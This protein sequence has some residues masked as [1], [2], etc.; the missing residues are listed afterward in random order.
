MIILLEFTAHDEELKDFLEQLNECKQKTLA[1]MPILER[2]KM[3]AVV[4]GW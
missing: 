3:K 4:F 2:D 1:I